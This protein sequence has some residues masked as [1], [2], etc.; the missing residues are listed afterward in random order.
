MGVIYISGRKLLLDE[1]LKLVRRVERV[2][3]NVE[4][5]NVTYIQN[6]PVVN[7]ADRI[8]SRLRGDNLNEHDFS[9]LLKA[10]TYSGLSRDYKSAELTSILHPNSG[11]LISTLQIH[12]NEEATF[13]ETNGFGIDITK[14][15]EKYHHLLEV[16]GK[17][18]KGVFRE[19]KE[20]QRKVQSHFKPLEKYLL[21]K[22]GYIS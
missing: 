20:L 7:L 13:Y 19:D 8:R 2:I 4:E 22:D 15:A 12:N 17:R 11:P 18:F 10:Q 21:I 3:D 9:I 14:E 16:F 1:R 6:T 5:Y